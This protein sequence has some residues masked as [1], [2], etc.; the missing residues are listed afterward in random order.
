EGVLVS[1]PRAQRE[2]TS[3]QQRVRDRED[4]AEPNGQLVARLRLSRDIDADGIR[5]YGSACDSH[6]PTSGRIARILTVTALDTNDLLD[7]FCAESGRGRRRHREDGCDAVVVARV[8][9][10]AVLALLGFES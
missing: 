7:T 2:E 9:E 5:R 6:W 3:D 10:R 8:D 1:K 4:D